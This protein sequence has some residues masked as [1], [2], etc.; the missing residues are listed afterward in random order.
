MK[1]NKS[2]LL[3]PNS[4]YHD[5][6]SPVG[7]LTIVASDGKITALLWENDLNLWQYK[8]MTTRMT[9][10]TNE[11]IIIQA[12]QQLA[13]YFQGTRQRFDLPLQP[14]GTDFQIKAWQQLQKIPYGQTI[15]Y[16][17]QAKRIGDKNKARAVGMANGCNPISIIIPC[18]RVIGSNGKLV[19]F[20]GGLD[21]K[22]FL[23]ALET[24]HA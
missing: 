21:K 8:A 16:G 24:K 13:E 1:K 19:G 7:R 20:G 3:P 11:K 22:S 9:D 2:L 14:N 12:K 4:I 6:D 15:S 5:M 18:H 17:E 23:L 10:S